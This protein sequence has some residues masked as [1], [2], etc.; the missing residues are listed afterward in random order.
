[1]FSCKPVVRAA[2]AALGVCA[3]TAPV[4]VAAAPKLGRYQCYQT[5]RQVSPITGAVGYSTTFQIALT[6]HRNGLYDVGLRSGAGRFADQ[7]ARIAFH[8]GPLDSNL[9]F[10]HVAGRYYPAGRTMPQSVLNPNRRYTIVLRDLRRSD[11][12]TAPPFQEFD[13]RQDATFWYCAR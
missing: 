1:M 13:A 5:T 12:D 10:W 4:A 11:A 8:G 9:D 6:L 3:V 2:I 7:G